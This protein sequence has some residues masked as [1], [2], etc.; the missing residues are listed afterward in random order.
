MDL[1][2][3]LPLFFYVLFTIYVTIGSYVIIFNLK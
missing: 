1:Q 3:I 2:K